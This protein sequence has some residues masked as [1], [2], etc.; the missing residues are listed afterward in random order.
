MNNSVNYSALN[1]KLMNFCLYGKLVFLFHLVNI[2]RNVKATSNL[3]LL[4]IK[5]SK[6]SN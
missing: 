3:E 5:E 4:K 2:P 1:K 6:D